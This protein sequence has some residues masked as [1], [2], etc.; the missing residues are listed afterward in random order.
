M[1][2]WFDPQGFNMKEP[3]LTDTPAPD[4]NHGASKST[5]GRPT[6]F[7]SILPSSSGDSHNNYSATVFNNQDSW[8]KH[9]KV[10]ENWRTV[11]ASAFL[12]F[13][14]LTL[15]ATGVVIA[16]TPARGYHCL[17]FGVIGLLC[18]IPG[19]YHFV[20][21]YC[22]AVGRPGYDFENLPVLR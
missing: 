21:I 14:G 16:F 13:L 7:R 2:L 22:A 11:I 18:L 9:P 15:L 19:G 4:S 12:S 10:K 6:S 20:Y 5:S 1:I 3:L 17:I 8:I